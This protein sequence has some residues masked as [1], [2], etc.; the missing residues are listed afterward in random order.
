[1]QPVPVFVDIIKFSDFQKINAD[2][3]KTHILSFLTTDHL[4]AEWRIWQEIF[5][6][7]SCSYY[8]SMHKPRGCIFSFSRN[9]ISQNYD[10]AKCF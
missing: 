9:K 3:S 8:S 7:Y 2:V 1:M 10:E 6:R 4:Q 5:L